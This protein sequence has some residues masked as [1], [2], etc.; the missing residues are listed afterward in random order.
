MIGIIL[1]LR[2]SIYIRRVVIRDLFVFG[3]LEMI[4]NGCFIVM[5]IV[6]FCIRLRGG[7]LGVGN[8]CSNSIF[9]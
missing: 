2:D 8:C 7:N 1:F 5:E 6:W 9:R 3:G 4:V